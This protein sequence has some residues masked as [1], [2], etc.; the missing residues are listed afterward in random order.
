MLWELPAPAGTVVGIVD[1]CDDDLYLVDPFPKIP[2]L[3]TVTTHMPETQ[4]LEPILA[5]DSELAKTGPAL[6][7]RTFRLRRVFLVLLAALL[8]NGAMVF[9]GFPKLSNYLTLTYSLNFGDLY[10]LIAKNLDQGNGYRVDAKMSETM[11]R[12]P[13]YPL[14]LAGI[15]ELGGYS[16]ETARIGCVLLAFGTA[17]MLLFLTQKITGDA[18]IALVSTLLF[19]LYPGILVAET[20]TGIEIPSVFTMTLF[21]LALYCAVEKASL[22]RYGVAG[23]LLGVAALVRSE[24]LLFPVLLLAYLLFA[25][26]GWAERRK[27]VGGIAVLTLGTAIVM[28]PWI[29]RNYKLVHS[30]VPTATVAGVAAQTGLYTC[31]NASPREPF[32]RVDGEAGLARAKIARQ[33][34]IPFVGPYYQLF[35]TPQDELTFNHVLLKDVATEYRNDPELLA[36][37]AAKNLL[38]NFWFLGKTPR[39]VMLNVLLQVPLLALA[40]AGVV[41]L[42]K[43]KVLRNAAIILL[44]V[45]YIPAVHAPILAQA[46]YSMLILP[47]LGVF[48]AIFLVSAWRTLRAWHSKAQ[49]GGVLGTRG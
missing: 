3:P 49:V 44:Y 1:Y 26:K 25:A 37:C 18:T 48:A 47:F 2:K 22:W 9:V 38:F 33:L 8:I 13:G 10:N 16:I 28:S 36:R 7:L 24:V 21:M 34:G 35:Y 14:F 32:F 42:W 45:L 4:R 23:L 5:D 17:L 11:L 27:I 41:V 20:R 31:K 19:L 29:I 43:R 40:F 12:E 15:F 6:P 30:F 46:R 39:S